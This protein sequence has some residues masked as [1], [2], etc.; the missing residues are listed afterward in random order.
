M[1]RPVRQNSVYFQEDRKHRIGN[2]V[3][4]RRVHCA[5]LQLFTQLTVTDLVNVVKQIGTVALIV[6]VVRWLGRSRDTAS[7]K[8][9]VGAS[10]YGIKWQLRLVGY[11]GAALFIGIVIWSRHDVV[12][13]R[14]VIVD[15]ILFEFGLLGLWFASGS[16][17]TNEGGVTKKGLFRSRSLRWCEITEVV[18]HRRDGGAIE[19]RAGPQKIIVDS[20]FLARTHLL[21]EIVAQTKLQPR[22]DN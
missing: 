19:L 11:S 6:I 17:I 21:N 13:S 7:P 1:W 10:V 4:N 2:D 18:L 14:D 5:G 12:S 16:V 20:R 9:R 3:I 22:Q 15:I 8:V